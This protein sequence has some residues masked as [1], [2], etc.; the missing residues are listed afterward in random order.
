MKPS[1]CLKDHEN[2]FCN[3]VIAFHEKLCPCIATIGI[4]E[5]SIADMLDN[6]QTRRSFQYVGINFVLPSRAYPRKEDM[7]VLLSNFLGLPIREII[8]KIRQIYGFE[9]RH[10]GV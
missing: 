2:S 6:R 9:L 7:G 1:I 8:E 4:D 10:C 3:R 5:D